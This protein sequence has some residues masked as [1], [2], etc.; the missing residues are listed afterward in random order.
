MENATSI[1]R[2]RGRP[3][4][5]NVEN[6]PNNVRHYR[7][8]KG[9]S[10]EELAARISVSVQALNRLELRNSLSVGRQKRYLLC[11]ILDA[12]ISDVFG[13]NF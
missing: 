5:V 3:A 10:P 2:Q 7:K 1:K 11:Q 6:L 4:H 13:D 9:L 12:S 8:K